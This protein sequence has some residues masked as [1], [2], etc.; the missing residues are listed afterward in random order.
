MK[1]K[2]KKTKYLWVNEIDMYVK[3]TD[4]LYADLISDEKIVIEEE[5]PT[6]I[7]ANPKKKNIYYEKV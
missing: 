7:F 1:T 6:M 2:E 3:I 5:Y 4:D